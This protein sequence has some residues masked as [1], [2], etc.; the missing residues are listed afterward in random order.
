MTS[1]ASNHPIHILPEDLS[2]AEVGATGAASGVGPE[3]GST[4]R[5]APMAGCPVVG[6]VTTGQPIVG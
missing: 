3:G 2:V 5:S 6:R 4:G 1:S